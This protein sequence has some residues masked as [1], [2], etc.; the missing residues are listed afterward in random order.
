MSEYVDESF[1]VRPPGVKDRTSAGGVVVRVDGGQILVGLTT[2]GTMGHYLIAKGGVKRG[3][4]LEETARREIREEAGFRELRLLGFLGIRERL[5]FE[6]TRWITT[7]YFLFLTDETD[8]QP[9][10]TK[11]DYSTDWFPI[12]ALPPMLWPDQR[13]LI[14]EAQAAI[15]ARILSSEEPAR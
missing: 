1:Y 5:N 14:E 2:I 7:H 3:E 8:P 9:T 4:T 12:D 13:M 10:E 11:Y 6:R 15:R